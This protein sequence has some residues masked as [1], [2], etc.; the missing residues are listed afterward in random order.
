MLALATLALVMQSNG[1]VGILQLI[2]LTCGQ[3]LLA[4]H[5]ATSSAGA[6]KVC[7]GLYSLSF[8]S[9]TGAEAN[10]GDEWIASTYC[11]K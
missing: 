3:T 10:N 8:L 5:S 9:S 1:D 4:D 7:V 6:E 11:S 2:G